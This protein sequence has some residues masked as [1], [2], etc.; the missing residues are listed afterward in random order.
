MTMSPEIKEYLE[1]MAA[2]SLPEEEFEAAGYEDE[3][4]FIADLDD[5]RLCGEYSTLMTMV[6]A[7][8][9]LLAAAA[10]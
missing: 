2:M 10:A 8:R 7:A 4:E 1:L 3:D 5:E 9:E 6:R